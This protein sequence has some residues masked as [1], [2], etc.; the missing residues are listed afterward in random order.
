MWTW[1][2]PDKPPPLSND[3]LRRMVEAIPPEADDP[4][5]RLFDLL[6]AGNRFDVPRWMVE[7]EFRKIW[8]QVIAD[9]RAGII[10]PADMGK[11]QD[12][13]KAEYR[14]IADRRVRLGVVIMAIGRRNN[15]VVTDEE[16][17]SFGKERKRSAL[18][19]TKIVEFIFAL[20]G[21]TP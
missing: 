2:F 1:L 20:A 11:S 5:G 6:D 8:R 19:E 7:N 16:A 17:A 4:R 14:A 13:L 21:R 10:D 12:Q 3:E 15:I 9:Q 18:L